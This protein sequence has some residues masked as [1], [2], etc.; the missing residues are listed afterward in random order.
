MM[1]ESAVQFPPES[2]IHPA[3]ETGTVSELPVQEVGLE[4]RL[5]GV[6]AELRDLRV[7]S[8][9]TVTYLVH[10]GAEAVV[11][12]AQRFGVRHASGTVVVVE[13]ETVT[14]I[15]IRIERVGDLVTKRS[16]VV[17][18]A[19]AAGAVGEIGIG[20]EARR[21]AEAAAHM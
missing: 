4:L 15:G 21:G 10:L 17:R 20:I 2:E 11:E 9:S 12:K 14:E 1:N 13:T 3:I 7:L 8:I 5:E 16:L 18:A 19:H 6:E